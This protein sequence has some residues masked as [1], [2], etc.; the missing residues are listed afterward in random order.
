MSYYALLGGTYLQKGT[1][2]YYYF[3]CTGSERFG[4]P[5]LLYY[6]DD[7]DDDDSSGSNCPREACMTALSSTPELRLLRLRRSGHDRTQF[8]INI[9]N[10]RQYVSQAGQE[11]SS[12]RSS[13]TSE[14]NPGLHTLSHAKNKQ[15]KTP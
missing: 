12:A 13:S 10:I 5:F 14:D 8:N 2:N 9:D 15:N 11:S 4:A 3:P 1:G 6:Y 7:D